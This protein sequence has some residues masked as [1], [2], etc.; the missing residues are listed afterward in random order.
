M[1]NREDSQAARAASAQVRSDMES[2]LCT[3]SSELVA[4]WNRSNQAFK[5]GYTTC[6][7]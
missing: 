7:S 5:A 2:L 1:K 3:A 4:H 6:L